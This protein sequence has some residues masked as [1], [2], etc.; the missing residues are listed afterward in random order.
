MATPS[1]NYTDRE[2]DLI[3]EALI[4]HVKAKFPNDWKDFTECLH[5]DTRVPLL[6]GTVH[7]L[8][9]LY[10]ANRGNF[11]VYSYDHSIGQVRPGKAVAKKTRENAIMVEVV[12]D[13]YRSIVATPDHEFMLR[14]GTYKEAQYLDTGDSLMPLYREFND[15]L[16]PGYERV[17]H[18]GIDEWEMTHYMLFEREKGKVIHHV[19]C[20]KLNNTPENLQQMDAREHRKMHADIWTR[21]NKSDEHRKSAS[22]SMKRRQSPGGDL[23]EYV[24]SIQR[25]EQVSEQMQGNQHRTGVPHTDAVKKQISQSVSEYNQTEAG[26]ARMQ[27]MQTASQNSEARKL[28]A[29]SPENAAKLKDYPPKCVLC[30][31]KAAVPQHIR[32]AH[33][34]TAAEYRAQTGLPNHKVLAVA[35]LEETVD[36]YCLVVEDH[37]NFA[38]EDGVFV[39]NSGIGMALLEITA[40]TYD[41]LS[42]Y[43]DVIA[44]ESFLPTA[45][46]RE[47]VILLTRLIGYKMRS[48]TSASLDM[49]ATLDAIQANDVILEVGTTFTTEGGVTFEFVSEQT[50]PTGSTT[51]T[52]TAVEGVTVTDSFTSDGTTFQEFKLSESPLIDGSITVEVDS[53]EWDEVDSLV[54]S[55]SVDQSYQV[56][57]DVDDFGYVK[58]GDGTSGLIPPNGA[59]IDISYRIGGGVAGNVAIGSV[60][61]TELQGK[62]SGVSPDTYVNVA[63]S[64]TERGSGGEDRESID[65]AKFWAPRSVATNGRAVTLQDFDTL[66]ST[67]TDPIYGAPA[68]AKAKLHQRVP[69]MNLVD[70]YLWA[71]DS[72]SN[73]VTPSENLK[74]AVS[75][76]FNN[77][78]AGAVRIITVDVDVLDGN[79][80]Y[81][82]LDV[83]IEPDGT[84]A[85]S[86]VLNSVTS[87]IE[88]YFSSASNQPGQDLRISLMYN[89][90]QNVDG[91]QHS[92]INSMTASYETS[93]TI[94]TSAGDTAQFDYLLF[95]QPVPGTI[96]ITAGSQTV[97]DDGNGNLIG[98]VNPAYQ[99]SVDYDTGRIDFSF[100]SIPPLLTTISIEYRYVLNYLR[101]EEDLHTLNGVK[102]TFKG[103]LKYFPLVPNTVSFTDTAQVISDDGDGTLSG[104]VDSNAVNYVDY[105]TG[106]Y[107]FTLTSAPDETLQI[108]STYEQLL[109]V[110]SI[111][112]PIDE[113][114]LAIKGFIDVSLRTDT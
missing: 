25:S 16:L 81:I 66:A 3:K 85:P 59:T 11:W 19:D 47:S 84:I 18:P 12:L 9:E 32:A 99:N 38:V 24:R 56:R 90:I 74:T 28:W 36:T 61:G 4:T 107:E 92:L 106:A 70:I 105:D 52:V 73:I 88:D 31:N 48:A 80:V 76:Y 49:V 45:K 29:R 13:N 83:S 5:P 42:Y 23:Y 71:R 6:D 94:G 97:T 104:D 114:Q 96:S 95:Q 109:S 67:F 30:E 91:V 68:Y 2:F 41:I 10:D 40:Y 22:D 1:I 7:T 87:T 108:N 35:F 98:D 14:D 27:K 79:N 17:Y 58:F 110:N 51:A 43:A 39:H 26:Q 57:T 102:R 53:F 34:M 111:D 60:D 72:E 103:Q 78:D 15:F 46:D 89:L 62:L 33:G 8:K 100:T 113:E 50:I 112:I 93:E 86:D 44:N 82:D 55:D 69:E 63:L 21:Y 65:S 101:G 20:N 77:N 64:N 37:F 75:E 54:Y